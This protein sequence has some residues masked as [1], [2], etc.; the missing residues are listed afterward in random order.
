MLNWAL[1]VV[2]GRIR[3]GERTVYWRMERV[4]AKAG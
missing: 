4:G 3:E 2:K 1:T